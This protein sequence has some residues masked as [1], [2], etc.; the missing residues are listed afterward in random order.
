MPAG[1]LALLMPR[2]TKMPALLVKGGQVFASEVRILLPGIGLNPI[3]RTMEKVI[4]RGLQ[5]TA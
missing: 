4:P 5:L 2:Q 1:G 3:G